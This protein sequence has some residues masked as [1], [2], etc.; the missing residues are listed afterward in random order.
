MKSACSNYELIPRL[1]PNDSDRRRGKRECPTFITIHETSIGTDLKD[2][3]CGTRYGVAYYES[4]LRTPN[5]NHVAYHYLVEAN[6]GEPSHVYMFLEPSVIAYHA[7]SPEGNLLS[8]GIERLVNT[9]T[10]MERAIATQANLTSNLMLTYL[11]PLSHVVPHKYWS[12]KECPGRL[13]AGLY[14]GWDGFIEQVKDHFAFN[15]G[16]SVLLDK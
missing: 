7:G 9:D 8:I 5:P 3:C 12:G 10:D 15:Y 6:Y 16:Y 13:L 4:V 14:G 2:T 11:I 1:L